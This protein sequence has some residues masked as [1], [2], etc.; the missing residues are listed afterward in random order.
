MSKYA[1][2]RSEEFVVNVGGRIGAAADL[3]SKLREAGVNVLASCCYQI[4]DEANLSFV[5][6]DPAHSEEALRDGGF[7]PER[8][9][10]LLVELHHETGSLAAL[11][12]EIR[13]VGVDIRSAYVTASSTKATAVLKTADNDRVLAALGGAEAPAPAAADE[14]DP[15]AS[16]ADEPDPEVGG[17]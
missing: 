15:E 1:P 16:S 6:E 17:E 10:V 3:F 8:Q 2:R 4:G 11:L 5:P 13:E 9:E 7:E 14:P 12:Q